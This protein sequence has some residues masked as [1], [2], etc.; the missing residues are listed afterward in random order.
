[1]AVKSEVG[2]AGFAEWDDWREVLAPYRR[3]TFNGYAETTLPLI[4]R[5]AIR[6][7]V[8]Q[9][10][11]R[12]DYTPD[13]NVDEITYNLRLWARMRSGLDLSLDTT[14]TRDKG[15]PQVA[16]EYTNTL[17]KASWRVRRFLL[18]AYLA[19]TKESQ[20]PTEQTHTRAQ[21]DLRRD[22]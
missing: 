2:E 6:L 17:A 19:R 8:Q 22:F 15:S 7:G 3:T 21:I 5:G 9:Q 18:T 16:R 20:G 12:Y 10:N 4:A 14:R 1:M 13:Q 11:T